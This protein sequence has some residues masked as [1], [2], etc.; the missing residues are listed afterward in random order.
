[1]TTHFDESKALNAVLLILKM[2]KGKID[3]HKLLKILYFADQKHIVKYGRPIFWDTYIAM[4]AGPVPSTLYDAIKSIDD[5]RYMFSLFKNNLTAE[6]Y[7]LMS[8]KEPD[9]DDLSQS[10]L[11]CLSDSVKEN[12][13]LSFED[14]TRKSHG[15]AWTNTGRDDRMDPCKIAIE[16]HASKEIIQYLK[17]NIED[18]E[19]SK[20]P[21]DESSC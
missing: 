5:P 6:G 2:Q 12:A 11:L 13:H 7:F 14:L 9:L 4:K 19:F 17:E 20:V 10:E 3:R 15:Y 18:F 16:G 8:D 1:M 21:L